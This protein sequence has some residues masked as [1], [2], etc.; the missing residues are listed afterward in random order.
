METEGEVVPMAGCAAKASSH[1]FTSTLNRS[2]PHAREQQGSVREVRWIH[3]GG[4]KRA[5][6]RSRA[7]YLVEPDAAG[8][9]E[10]VGER[11]EGGGGGQ[12]GGETV[13]TVHAPHILHSQRLQRRH[14]RRWLARLRKT[15]Q[16]RLGIQTVQS[17][18]LV[19]WG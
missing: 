18:I 1:P 12:G 3:T 11:G 19:W 17:K 15:L 2:R 10:R 14:R 13:A 7:T 8:G 5:L 16:L 9:E 4:R 6:R